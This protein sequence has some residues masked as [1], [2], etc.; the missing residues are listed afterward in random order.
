MILFKHIPPHLWVSDEG[1]RIARL[2]RPRGDTRPDRYRVRYNGDEI[3]GDQYSF[4]AA[5]GMGNRH[6]NERIGV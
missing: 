1:Y 5:V 6:M 3:G 4:N 2:V